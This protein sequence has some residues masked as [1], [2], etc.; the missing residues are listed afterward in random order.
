MKKIINI[1]DLNASKVFCTAPWTHLHSFPNGDVVACCLSPAEEVIGNLNDQSLEEIWNNDKIKQLRL[2][3][4]ND[5]ESPEICGRCYAKE[6]E[7]FQSLRVGMNQKYLAKQED[8]TIID[9]TEDDGRVEKMNLLHWDFR[10]S[11][12]CNLSCRSCGPGLSSSWMKDHKKLWNIA[13]EV[14]AL[15]KLPEDRNALL[16]ADA[17]KNID[18]VQSIHFAGGEPMMMEEHWT[19]LEALKEAGRKDVKIHY[20]TNMTRFK[21]GKKHAFDYWHDFE[22]LYVSASIDEIGDRFNYIRNGGNWDSVKQNLIDIKNQNFKNLELAFHP[23]LSVFNITSFP[24]M[25]KFIW[26]NDSFQG[27]L[28]PQQIL[29]YYVHIVNL[30]PLTYP[31]FYAM[32]ILPPELKAKAA[33]GIEDL[34]KWTEETIYIEN[35]DGFGTHRKTCDTRP[36]QALIEFMYAADDSDKL[37]HFIQYTENLDAIRDQSF[38]STFP[39]L[40]ELNAYR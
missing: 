14:P 9:S 34:I 7:G 31:D 11:N 21:F 6:K 3:M 35:V 33:K 26:D 2:D 4:L 36:L 32:T 40:S 17:L 15:A 27:K 10:F 8:L 18:I 20:S 13:A 29:H 24:E 37:K 25:V 39:E 1:K 12:L 28:K 23:T 38:W 5:V 19:I 30:N 22:S 16:L